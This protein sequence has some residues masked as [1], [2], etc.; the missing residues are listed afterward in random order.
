MILA[1]LAANGRTGR[2][3]VHAALERGHHVRADVRSPSGNEF[4]HPDVTI[5]DCDALD[6]ASVLALVQGS[7]LGF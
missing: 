7:D 6:P 5:I 1:V 4:D 2:A 3:V